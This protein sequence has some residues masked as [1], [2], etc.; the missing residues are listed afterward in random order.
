MIA[1]LTA[2]ACAAFHPTP[3]LDRPGG[4]FGC[5]PRD[6]ASD[7]CSGRIP[8]IALLTAAAC[9]AFPPSAAGATPWR[10]IDL[11]SAVRLNCINLMR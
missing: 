4:I 11:F 10:G 3:M 6:R 2:A 9:A 5:V 1:L 7:R 8:V